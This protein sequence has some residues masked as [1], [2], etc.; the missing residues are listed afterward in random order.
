MT[1]EE[2]NEQFGVRG[3]ARFQTRA[4]GLT[5]LDVTASGGEAQVYLLGAHVAHWQP[6]G[7]QSVLWL[8]EKSWFEPLKPIRG[9]VPVCWPWF[10]PKEGEPN[11]PAHGFARLAE[12]AVESVTREA[13]DVSVCLLLAG[14]ANEKW[15]GFELRHRVRVGRTLTMSLETRNVGRE[16]FTIAEALHTYFRVSDVRNVSVAGL[17]GVEY[18]DKVDGAKRKR[19]GDEPIR[20]SGETDRVYLNTMGECV[21]DDAGANRRIVIAKRGSRSTVVWNP[22]AAKAARMPDFGDDEWPGMVCVETANADHNAVTVAAG[23]SH[24]MEASI[25]VV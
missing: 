2:L 6:G 21:L 18:I 24:V 5:R 23:Q 25:A 20:F 3:A 13:G 22:W 14:G 10:G 9:G 15:G 7:E 1:S 8:S 17:A 4:G 11:A 16:A 19:Q 12:W